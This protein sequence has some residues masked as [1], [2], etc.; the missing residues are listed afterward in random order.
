MILTG[1]GTDLLALHPKVGHEVSFFLFLL[2]HSS[3]LGAVFFYQRDAVV[4][5]PSMVRSWRG[6]IGEVLIDL[7]LG[8]AAVMLRACL[9]VVFY[10]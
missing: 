10:D 2:G 9:S 3:C 1:T 6:E 7:L 8:L 5:L 4:S